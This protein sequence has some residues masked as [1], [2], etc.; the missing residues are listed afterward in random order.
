[1]IRTRRK[2]VPQLKAPSRLR[3][4]DFQTP[5]TRA[6][7]DSQTTSPRRRRSRARQ[8]A[9]PRPRSAA[10]NSSH[11]APT[12]PAPPAKSPADKSPPTARKNPRHP[13]QSQGTHPGGTTRAELGK[14]LRA[15]PADSPPNVRAPCAGAPPPAPTSS[16]AEPTLKPSP[17]PPPAA[18]RTAVPASPPV[19]CRFQRLF[20]AHPPRPTRH[21]QHGAESRRPLPHFF[22]SAGAAADSVAEPTAAGG[23]G[24]TGPARQNNFVRP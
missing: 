22:E 9:P 21:Q 10:A 15:S 5:I 7:S 24:R 4:A 13:V 6:R 2:S 20:R 16:R 3:R 14:P 1:M 12:P 18:I 8:T 23:R 17:H 19:A 11:P